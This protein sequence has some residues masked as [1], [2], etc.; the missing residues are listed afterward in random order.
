MV[1][2]IIRPEV[3]ADWTAPDEGCKLE[4]STSID[5]LVHQLASIAGDPATGEVWFEF[6]VNNQS[7]QVPIREISSLLASV[8][9]LK[10]W[11]ARVIASAERDA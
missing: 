1:K 11:Q 6:Y 5:G 3:R 7:V 10:T 4:L 2:P 8:P 9:E